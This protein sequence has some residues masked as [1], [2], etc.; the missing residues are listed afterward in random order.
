MPDESSDAADFRDALNGVELVADEPVLHRAQ[1]AEVVAPLRRPGR[2]DGQV[3]L[4][5]PAQAGGVR[6]K[7]RNHAGGHLAGD[8]AEP[9]QHP[10]AR[11][12]ILD[13]VLED[14]R[15]QRKAKHRVGANRL[16]AGE[17]L[18]VDGERVSDLV[19]HFL[20]T[21]SQQLGKDDDLVFA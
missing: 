9:F 20:R 3:I 11:E 1:L 17:P 19:F 18:Q 12:V 21:A 13:V 16:H 5:N 2:I 8:E 6:P 14:H 10:G 4:V 7:L 15:D